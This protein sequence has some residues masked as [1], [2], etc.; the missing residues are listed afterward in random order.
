MPP[1]GGAPGAFRSCPAGGLVV[2]FPSVRF[3][4]A[5]IL[6]GALAS[7][8]AGGLT[9]LGAFAPWESALFPASLRAV[10]FPIDALAIPLL[11]FGL[12]WTTLDIGP[13]SLRLVVAGAALLEVA[14]LSWVLARFG[15]GW[16]PFG[17]L[18]AGAIATLAA[19]LHGERPAGRWRHESRALFRGRTSPA[20][21]RRIASGVPPARLSGAPVEVSLL[22]LELGEPGTAPEATPDP[23]T[24]AAREITAGG[25]IIESWEPHRLT[26]FFGG[27]T[28]ADPARAATAA[29]QAALDIRHRL[30]AFGDVP[31]SLAV[32]SGAGI[33]GVHPAGAASRYRISG[34]I[35]RF[36]ARLCRANALYGTRLLIG[37]ETFRLSEP[38]FE[39]RPVELLHDGDTRP[40]AEIYELLAPAGHLGEEELARRDR[41]W[42]AVVLF[43]RHCPQEAARILRSLPE[44]DG[45]TR[46][47]LRRIASGEETGPTLHDLP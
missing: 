6:C 26:A 33:A 16:P 44:E 11:G 19:F 27:V 37:P 12:A 45:P 4:P 31:F 8:L 22:V 2:L 23:L 32:H 29:A 24:L 36:A 9:A 7:G 3:F 15:F 5:F 14:L 41:F 47:Y 21:L 20:L 46:L 18:A 30:E 43:R 42:Q 39:V 25:G 34:E 1:G 35:C 40:W 13:R 17:S 38:A 28:G 10:P